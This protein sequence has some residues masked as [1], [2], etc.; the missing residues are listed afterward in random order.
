MLDLKKKRTDSPRPGPIAVFPRPFFSG[1]ARYNAA[2]RFAAA[3]D[4]GCCWLQVGPGAVSLRTAAL[5]TPGGGSRAAAAVVGE[6]IQAAPAISVRCRCDWQPIDDPDCSAPA[7]QWL[8]P[9]SAFVL[10]ALRE[11]VPNEGLSFEETK[12]EAIAHKK[13]RTPWLRYLLLLRFAAE[14]RQDTS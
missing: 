14:H 9:G 4:P 11:Q 6:E 12:G 1:S 10:A 5:A 8:G 2:V 3:A 7:V 13:E